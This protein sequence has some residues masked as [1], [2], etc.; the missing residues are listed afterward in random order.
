VIFNPVC[1]DP[2]GGTSIKRYTYKEI[3]KTTENFNQLNKIGEGGFGSVYKVMFNFQVR[4][5][6]SC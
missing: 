3:V 2:S 1:V 5:Y 6:R 4:R